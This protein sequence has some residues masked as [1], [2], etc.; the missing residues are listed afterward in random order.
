MKTL[1]TSLEDYLE[2]AYTLSR[3]D[4]FCRATGISR[5]LKVSK[6]SV[7]AAVKALAARG[8]LEHERYGYIRLSPSGTKAGAEIAARHLLLKDF[9]ISVLAMD[10]GQAEL[11]ACRAEHAL[12]PGA[13]DRVGALAVFLKSAPRRRLLQAARSAVSAR[14]AL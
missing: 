3:K 12:S 6:P 4:G 13:L 7:N 11:D 8:L 2:A 10:P 14:R 5:Q 9:F 1:S